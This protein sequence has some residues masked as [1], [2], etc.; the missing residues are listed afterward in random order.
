MY[1][2]YIILCYYFILLFYIIYIYI[3]VIYIYIYIFV[4]VN[5]LVRANWILCIK[6]GEKSKW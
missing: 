5:Y 4:K 6:T 1:M 2:Q 3:Y